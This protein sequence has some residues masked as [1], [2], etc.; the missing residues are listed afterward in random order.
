MLLSEYS[1]LSPLG[2]TDYLAA[3][4]FYTLDLFSLLALS[5]F[6][7]N[8]AFQE[9]EDLTASLENNR[10]YLSDSYGDFLFN[11]DEYLWMPVRTY[12]KKR[13]L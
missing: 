1:F 6:L 3:Y 12:Y 9:Y 7:L 13:L 11:N 4:G 5:F 8:R 2:G 10:N